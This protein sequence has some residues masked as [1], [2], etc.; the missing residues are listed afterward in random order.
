MLTRKIAE[1]IVKEASFRVNRNVNIMNMDGIIIATCETSRLN[2]IHEGALKVLNSGQ[3]LFIYPKEGN[4]LT[5]VKPGVNLPIV[6]QEK[7]IGVIGITGD[8]NEISEISQLVKMM[9][10]LMIN[11]KHT[12][13]LHE[14]KQRTK[15]M[16]L[17]Q[18]LKKELSYN[19]INRLTSGINFEFIP[20]FITIIIQIEERYTSNQTLVERLEN[21][22]GQK[23]GLIGFINV[24]RL[25]IALTDTTKTDTDK[26]KY[27]VHSVL[28]N[29]N[30]K[31]RM[32]YSLPFNKLKDFRASYLDCDLALKISDTKK[33]IISFEQMEAKALI[34]RLDHQNSERF[35][36][37]LLKNLDEINFKT[38]E[39]FFDHNLN[40]QKAADE[41]YV[42]RNTLIY[43]LNKITEHT[44]L[45]PRKFGN[46]LSLQMALWINE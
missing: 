18:L 12:Q 3:P 19:D 14:W 24:N 20:M 21:A 33:E 5:G 13:S 29:L 25:C 40:I 9:T 36:N 4:E 8:P 28:K 6:F 45:D 10:E 30:I 11:Q 42:H 7:V 16:I 44:G 43:R 22:I 37:R 17:I 32:S 27:A 23:N 34:Y 38:L 26:K 31:F 1:T 2:H 46:A 35:A 39:T 15:D 41:L